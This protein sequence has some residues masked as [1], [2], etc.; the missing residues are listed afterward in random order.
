VIWLKK[1]YGNKV[2]I[3]V[4]PQETASNYTKVVDEI[5][6][7]LR[8]RSE[9]FKTEW[10]GLA[11]PT[12]PLRNHQ[13]VAKALDVFESTNYPLFSCNAYDFPVQF[14]F[15][16]NYE[17]SQS[18]NWR[19][20]F[21][22]SPMITGNTRSQDIEKLLR[23]NGAIYINKKSNFLESKILYK[24]ANAFEISQIE[25]M[26]IDTELDFKIVEKII[27]ENNE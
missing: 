21:K 1:K 10:F 14:A 13:T 25:S 2:I 23:P 6:R 27:K 4:R 5:E 15:R 22:E 3:E 16:V 19:P 9:L 17:E 12:A 7:L 11:L 24:N 18:Q 26:D 8:F 20:I